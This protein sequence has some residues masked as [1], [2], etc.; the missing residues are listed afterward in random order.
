[1]LMALI[2]GI[3]HPYVAEFKEA[4]VEKVGAFLV[5]RR[6]EVYSVRTQFW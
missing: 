2:A 1:M 6:G 4:W 3:Q 5:S